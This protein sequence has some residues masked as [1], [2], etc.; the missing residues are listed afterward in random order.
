MAAARWS[1]KK[2][3]MRSL[4][5]TS[6][7]VTKACFAPLG[8]PSL[9]T[10]ALVCYFPFRIP[11]RLLGYAAVSPACCRVAKAAHVFALSPS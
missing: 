5:L 7:L 1:I 10:S 4:S 2:D 6:T 11:S 9:H 8:I 3:T